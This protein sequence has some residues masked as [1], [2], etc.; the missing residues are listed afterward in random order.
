MLVRNAICGCG[1]CLM[2]LRRVLVLIALLAMTAWMAPQAA[3]KDI[4]LGGQRYTPDQ[5]LP[6]TMVEL[7]GISVALRDDKG[8]WRHVEIHAW[9]ALKDSSAAYAVDRKRWAI[10][11]TVKDK[12]PEADFDVLAAAHTGSALAKEVIRSAAMAALGEELAGD[13]LI[14]E[15][16]VY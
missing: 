6:R 14:R 4:N 10:A 8:G 12:L 16:L 3:A 9:L 13:V 2:L 7:P 11:R 15:L 1:D 5:N